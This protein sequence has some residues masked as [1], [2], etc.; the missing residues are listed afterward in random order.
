MGVE[1]NIYSP[2]QA[3]D[4][5]D[6]I[7][8]AQRPFA[9]NLR[10]FLRDNRR[11]QIRYNKVNSN[12]M[13]YRSLGKN[14]E[15]SLNIRTADDL[16]VVA[17]FLLNRRDLLNYNKLG[18]E[19]KKTY[20][21]FTNADYVGNNE[22]INS[23]EAE[24]EDWL[25][26]VRDRDI[27][28]IKNPR[29][30]RYIYDETVV[31]NRQ[32]RNVFGNIKLRKVKYSQ[33]E[34]YHNIDYDINEY[35]VPSFLSSKLA[36]KEYKIISDELDEIKTPT[37]IQLTNM[38]NK[39]DYNLNVFILDGENIQ[40]QE[41]YQKT[42]NIMIHDEHMYVLKL[43]NGSFTKNHTKVEEVDKDTYDELKS[44][45]CSSDYKLVNG[46]KYKCKNSFAECNKEFNFRNT[47]SQTN[48]DFFLNSGIRPIRYINNDDNIEIVQALDINNCYPN[49][50]HNEKYEFPVQDGTE[51]TQIFNNTDEIK[52]HGFY[53]CT[54]NN[55][56]DIYNILFGTHDCWILGYLIVEMKMQKDITIHYKH[57]KE[58]FFNGNEKIFYNN[59]GNKDNKKVDEK[60]FLSRRLE[61][62]FYTGY[63]AK[64][65]STNT[66]NYYCNNEEADA[67]EIK[68][69]D[70]SYFTYGYCFRKWKDETT[71]K[72]KQET[73]YYHSED[74]KQELLNKY[75]EDKI[76]KY[77][78]PCITIE[79]DHYMQ[80]S[81]LYSYLAIL[82]YARLQ[83]FHIY[84]E[85]KS[86]NPNITVKKV[87]TDSITFNHKLS[88]NI[89]AYVIEINKTLKKY[90]VQVKK[91]KSTYTWMHNEIVATVPKVENI[92]LTKYDD[93]NKLLQKKQSFCIN[94]KAGYGKTHTINNVIIPYFK[95][96]NIRYTITSTTIENAKMLECICINSLIANKEASLAHI[97]K[98]FKNIDYLVIDECSRLT[99][100]LLNILQHIKKTCDTK[101]IFCGDENQCDYKTIMHIDTIMTTD[102]FYNLCDSN[103]YNILWHEHARYN[104][105][106]DDVLNGVLSLYDILPKKLFMKYIKSCFNP[107]QIKNIDDIKNDKNKIK[108]SWTNDFKH[109]FENIKEHKTVHKSQGY[110][111]NEPYSIYEIERMSKKVLYTALSRCTKPELITIYF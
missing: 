5:I 45:I 33:L 2:A 66:Q 82:Q 56:K 7:A 37:Y 6:W 99:M 63:L 60:K 29:T 65:K 16:F 108:L 18:G 38:L 10:R 100:H 43:N 92:K 35:C 17:C 23:F 51:T 28:K 24:L 49:I 105:E 59:N 20:L 47:Y 61:Y 22:F 14:Q 9:D 11:Y 103:I 84:Q 31:D 98:T 67:L 70:K 46:I 21:L 55:K 64:Y 83:L 48:V 32:Y 57:I 109:N 95:Q 8:M 53:Y 25:E 3:D 79:E 97:E 74:E 72:W 91:E 106:Y 87:Y 4:E 40:K 13:T 80:T 89:D 104:K 54:I 36:K 90:R 52:K 50:I 30:N 96:Q 39:I 58:N 71:N 81:G 77:Y 73:H 62:I 93:M 88:D 68:Y 44:E 15:W 41:Q 26:P 12:A 85:V 110:T 107:E 102:L 34:N 86:I 94:A 78:D 42:L 27:G 76:N 101:F 1:Y 75:P 111:I 19:L 69:K